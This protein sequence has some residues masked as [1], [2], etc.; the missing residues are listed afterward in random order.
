WE[1]KNVLLIIQL[2]DGTTGLGE[3]APFPAVSGE[4]Q[5][6]TLDCLSRI[7]QYIIGKNVY[8]WETLAAFIRKQEP[9]FP[10][11]CCAVEMAMLDALTRYKKIPLYRFFGGAGTVLKTDMTITAGNI[12]HAASSAKAIVNRGIGTIKIK[13]SGQDI[14]FDV[15]RVLAIHTAAPHASLIIDG[16]CGYSAESALQ[17]VRQLSSSGIHPVLLEQPLPR[18]D[19]GGMARLVK[20]SG[21]C[22]AADE[23]ARSEED[24]LNLIREKAAHVINIKLMKCGVSEALKMI[25]AAQKAGLDLMIGGMVE[26]ILAMTFSAHLAAGKGNFKFVDLDTPMFIK[27]HPFKGGF[28]QSG[29]LLTLDKEGVGHGVC[30]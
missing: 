26:S 7:S 8:E 21:L 1:A 27:S 24:V 11:A 29:E 16:N 13:T 23:S 30:L 10:S 28:T 5:E 20:E 9:G 17:F 19:L 2:S 14:D 15:K 6:G 12:E 4:T 22:I 25:D 3:A 18:E